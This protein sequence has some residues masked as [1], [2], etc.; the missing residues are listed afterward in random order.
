M[1]DCLSL[2]DNSQQ[3]GVCVCTRLKLYLLLWLAVSGRRV[4]SQ[5]VLQELLERDQVDLQ[6]LQFGGQQISRL[7]LGSCSSQ[8]IGALSERRQARHLLL[9]LQEHLLHGAGTNTLR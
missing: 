4:L 9:D 7:L 3:G 8:V 5:S 1:E 6:E 2:S